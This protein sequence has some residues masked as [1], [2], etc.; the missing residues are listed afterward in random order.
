VKDELCKAFCNEIRLRDVPAGV[1]VST[2][3]DGLGGEPIGFYIVGPDGAGR[4]HLEDDGT[5][6]PLLEALGADRDNKTRV[7]AFDAMLEEYSAEFNEETGEL[8][9]KPVPVEHLPQAAMKFVALLLRLQDLELLT[10]ERVASTF[11]EDATHALVEIFKDRN[12]VIKEEE[13][14]APSIEFPAD[15]IIQAPERDPV[16]VF[17]AATE[18]KLLEAVVA[19]M[20]AMYETHTVCSVIALLDK[21]TSVNKKTRTKAANRLAAV[22]YYEGDESAAIRRIEREVLGPQIGTVH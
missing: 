16:A 11:K 22:T 19:Q 10:P 13:P 20:A 12:V 18:Q 3:F 15:L 1:A 9:T 8:L 5:T 6:V 4:Y 7:E 21:D 17:L 14:I 2:G